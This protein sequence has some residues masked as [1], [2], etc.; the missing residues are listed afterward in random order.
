[1][2]CQWAQSNIEKQQK[3]NPSGGCETRTWL[4]H[5]FKEMRKKEKQPPPKIILTAGLKKNIKFNFAPPPLGVPQARTT[6]LQEKLLTTPTFS[7]TPYASLMHMQD[8]GT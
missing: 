2:A 4:T 6:C 8:E 5:H 1:M 3:R 7:T